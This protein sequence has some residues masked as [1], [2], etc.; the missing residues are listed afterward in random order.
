L[1]KLYI[2]IEGGNTDLIEK[3]DWGDNT[4]SN[5][6]GPFKSGKVVNTS[7]IWGEP[8]NYEVKVKSRDVN[9]I[10]SPWSESLYV[11]IEN[12]KVFMFG[13]IDSKTIKENEISLDEENLLLFSLKPFNLIRY[14]QSVYVYIEIDYLGIFTN[15]III[16][17]FN[18]K[19][20]D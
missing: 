18:I 4:K 11:E 6:I 15:N 9:N 17:K 13:I 14:N 16:G 3:F 20:I 5:C 2:S 12:N 19:E 1:F 10:E 7:H 8:D